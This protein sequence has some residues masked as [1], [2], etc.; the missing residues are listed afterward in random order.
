M[1]VSSNLYDQAEYCLVGS[2]LRFVDGKMFKISFLILILS[3]VCFFTQIKNHFSIPISVFE[4]D[5]L[6][7]IAS[8]EN[9]FNIPLASYR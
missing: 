8:P 1:F 2:I 3:M 5:T 6:L 7:G 4:G 9:E